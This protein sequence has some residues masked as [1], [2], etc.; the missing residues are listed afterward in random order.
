MLVIRAN[1]TVLGALSDIGMG[2][3]RIMELIDDGH[4]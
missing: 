1:R 4:V 2:D 3:I